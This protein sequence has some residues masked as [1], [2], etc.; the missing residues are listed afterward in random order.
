MSQRA[1][2]VVTIAMKASKK[3]RLVLTLR[4]NVGACFATTMSKA[5]TRYFEHVADHW[6]ELRSGYFG[7]AVRVAAIARASLRQGMEV[8]DVGSG[9]GFVAAALAPL[10]ARV[11]VTDGSA[12]MLKVARRN[13]AA[14]S[15]VKYHHADG[16]S[17]PFSDE[18]LDAVFANMYLHHC[19]DPLTAISEMV[20]VLRSGGRLVITDL[21][22]H[23][24]TWF[25]TEMAD[26]WLGFERSTIRTY[27]CQA[28]LVDV[29]VDCTGES[30]RID[31]DASCP[32]EHG[33]RAAKVSIFVASGARSEAQ[34]QRAGHS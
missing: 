30:C 24:Y 8:A 1:D 19:P 13:L 34:P 15:N 7:E 31:S 22:T 9:T 17:L 33:V 26:E 6:D 5:S 16:G 11:H 29:A 12:A 10:V 3:T 28:G 18:S 21:D 4:C 27:L 2:I 25:R 23:A 32:D 20:R 14:F